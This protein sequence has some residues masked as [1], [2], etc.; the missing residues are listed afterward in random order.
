MEH[1]PTEQVESARDDDEAT[2]I[3]SKPAVTI[4]HSH[5]GFAAGKI[6]YSSV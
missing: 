5:F 4:P 3:A 6:L 1:A 2:L